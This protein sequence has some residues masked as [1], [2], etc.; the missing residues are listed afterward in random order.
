MKRLISKMK[1]NTTRRGFT[2]AEVVVALTV[3]VLVTGTTMTFIGRHIIRE[4][5]TIQSVS[6]T[7]IAE[8]AIE[9]FRYSQNNSDKSFS[10]LFE[11]T[12][13]KNDITKEGNTYTVKKDGLT[14]EITIDNN[15]ITT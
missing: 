7:N 15:T 14:V 4:T 11:K 6:A 9:C 5:R 1:K 12:V 3:I 13:N 8:N 10:D 2:V